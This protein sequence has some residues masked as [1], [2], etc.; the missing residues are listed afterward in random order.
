MKITFL[1][2]GAWGT[3]L[4]ICA[5]E[6]NNDVTMWAPFP[7]E[8]EYIEAHGENKLLPGV[9]LPP[10]KICDD[11][12]CAA[13]ADLCI[14]AV[15]SFAIRDVALRAQNIISRGTILVSI[16]KGF[17][18]VRG[19]RLSEVIREVFPENPIAVLC[20][21]SH[22]EEV[23]RRIPT[24]LVSSCA[25]RAAAQTVQEA[26]ASDRLRIYLNTDVIGAE[27]G[28]A[29]KNVIA[30]AAGVCDGMGMGDNTKAALMTR[31][32]KEMAAL[33]TAM[34]ADPKTFSGLTGMGDL[35]VTC[36]SMHSRNR[37]AGILIGK[38]VSTEQA[39]REVGTV[40][41]YYATRIVRMLSE[42]YNVNMPINDVCYRACYESLSAEE[43][44]SLLMNRPQKD[45]L[46]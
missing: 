35:I 4:A 2:T 27:L 15:P 24:A 40:E 10:L 43:A 37:R 18:A 8:R 19:D 31:G 9:P 23:S 12:A 14:F 45:E 13:D 1:G 21:P 41:G 36:T 32:L 7:A 26:F 28:A 5:Y 17:D 34:G 38:G 29:V 16:A 11:L 46:A 30:L 39:L 42:K 3:A 33:G 25:D 20:G 44:L 22:A 6:N